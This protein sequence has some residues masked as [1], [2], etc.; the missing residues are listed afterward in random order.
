MNFFSAK[1]VFNCALELINTIYETI[2]SSNDEID[3]E[4]K[5]SLLS[6]PIIPLI[7]DLMLLSNSEWKELETKCNNCVIHFDWLNSNT[8]FDQ[9]N[10]DFV[11]NER[12]FQNDCIPF[13]MSAI[14][15]SYIL[16]KLIKDNS[17]NKLTKE[18]VEVISSQLKHLFVASAYASS[19]SKFSKSKDFLTNSL[20]LRELLSNIMQS[21][22][23]IKIGQLLLQ[24]LVLFCH[25]N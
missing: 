19:K 16:E 4:S 8:L 18:L 1:L 23:N 24:K 15:T 14:S 12:I 25:F 13:I 22:E 2:N 9:Q 7:L 3:D 21:I 6:N 10:C 20:I 17:N 11:E 5:D